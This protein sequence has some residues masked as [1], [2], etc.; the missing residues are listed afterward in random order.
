MAG[1]PGE[2]LGGHEMMDASVVA[3]VIAGDPVLPLHQIDAVKPFIPNPIENHHLFGAG[4]LLVGVL[5]IVETLS[6]RIWHRNRARTLVFPA[7]VMFLG[8]G[9]LGVT[10]LDTAQRP[11]HF[12][13]GLV[14]IAAGWTE[15]R[16]RLGEVPRRTADMWI[17]PALLAGAVEVG[18]F[19]FHGS[20][21]NSGTF[22]A[23]LGITAAMMAVV[24]VLQSRQ[25][26]SVPRHAFMGVL[27][28]IMALQLMAL[29]H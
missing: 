17:V 14:M 27:M 23:L 9:M 16:Y 28:V 10:A 13:I 4:F 8:A 3:P 25:P 12:A 18:V 6:G 22:H 1:V 15:A 11:V 24:R 20:F 26:L 21:S 7:T 2:Q 29:N 19:H 5:L